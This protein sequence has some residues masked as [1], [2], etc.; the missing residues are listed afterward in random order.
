[1][2]RRK[3]LIGAGSVA[4]GGAAVLGTGAFNQATAERDVTVTVADDSEAYLTLDPDT[5]RNS[6][7]ASETSGTVRV[8]IGE[9]DRGGAGIN[10][11]GRTFLFELFEIRNQGTEPVIAYVNP[12]SV[13]L[14]SSKMSS[15]ADDGTEDFLDPQATNRPNSSTSFVDS[16]PSGYDTLS[17]TAIYQPADGNEVPDPPNFRDTANSLYSSGAGVNEFELG[18]GGGYSFGLYIR[19]GKDDNDGFDDV[20]MEIVADTNIAQ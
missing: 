15:V 2:Q 6:E 7:F 8:D 4:A 13:T 5:G 18:A 10:K 12:D 1:M 20:S 14:G 16:E 17:M 3:F 19:E 9:N 11:G